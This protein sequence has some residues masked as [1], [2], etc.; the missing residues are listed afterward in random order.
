MHS[1][2]GATSTT[3]A[4]VCI[5]FLVAPAQ[6]SGE[7]DGKCYPSQV[8]QRWNT[9]DNKPGTA[10][11]EQVKKVRK[12]EFDPRFDCSMEIRRR[13]QLEFDIADKMNCKL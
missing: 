9:N 10:C 2:Y 13:W 11:Y 5:F 8:D 7:E 4:S 12:L 3:L 1:K 6:S